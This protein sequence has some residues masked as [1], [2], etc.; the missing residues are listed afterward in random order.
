MRKQEIVRKYSRLL[1]HESLGPKT[2]DI[3]PVSLLE[4]PGRFQSK[5]SIELILGLISRTVGVQTGKAI[6]EMMQLP[7]VYT[8][9]LDGR[10]AHP[11]VPGGTW[12]KEGTQ[13]L[14]R[15]GFW[16]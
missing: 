9:L 14:S 2:R 15:I 1:D 3:R 8:V 10:Y 7:I 11:A 12:T 6:I 16:K 5:S 13:W 4:N